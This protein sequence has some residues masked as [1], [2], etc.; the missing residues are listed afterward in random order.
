MYIWQKFCKKFARIV[1]PV[2]QGSIWNIIPGFPPIQKKAEHTLPWQAP[3]DM[4]LI[5]VWIIKVYDAR[6]TILRAIYGSG[7]YLLCSIIGKAYDCRLN[8]HWILYDSVYDLSRSI[9]GKLLNVVTEQMFWLKIE[10]FFQSK[11]FLITDL[12]TLSQSASFRVSCK[13]FLIDVKWISKSTRNWDMLIKSKQYLSKELL[14]KL[15]SCEFQI[16]TSINNST[17]FWFTSLIPK[18]NYR[19]VQPVALNIWKKI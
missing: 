6:P 18:I 3:C 8:I 1:I 5:M 4:R 12:K 16:F 15:L 11:G 14:K 9:N 2:N 7:Y 17:D 10:F 19:M 13:F